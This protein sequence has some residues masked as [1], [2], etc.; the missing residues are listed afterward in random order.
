VALVVNQRA[1]TASEV[2]LLDNRDAEAGLGQT[3]GEGNTTGSSA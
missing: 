3:R 1:A 2:V